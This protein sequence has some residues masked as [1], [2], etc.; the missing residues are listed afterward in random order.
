MSLVK[1]EQLSW[2]ITWCTR[3]MF[4]CL[5]FVLVQACQRGRLWISGEHRDQ[6][7][8]GGLVKLVEEVPVHLADAAG[9]VVEALQEVLEDGGGPEGEGEGGDGLVDGDDDVRRGLEDVG[10]YKVE[11]VDEG[12]LA[13]E[14]DHVEGHVLDD[15]AGGL[16]VDEVALAEGV[17]QEGHH[18][19]QVVAGEVAGDVLEHEGQRLEHSRANV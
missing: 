19:V 18:R 7:L 6:S 13:A 9:G 12:V 4:D 17:L 1:Q 2:S 8:G 5:S 10:P 14:A 16:A 15:G 11:Q 3:P